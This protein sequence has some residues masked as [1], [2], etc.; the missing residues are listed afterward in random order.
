MK[1]IQLKKWGVLTAYIL[2]CGIFLERSLKPT[3]EE[4]SRLKGTLNAL[5]EERQALEIEKNDLTMQINSQSDPAWV[6][7]MLM[8]GLGLIPEGQIKVFFDQSKIAGS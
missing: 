6:E 7:L 5:Q 8:K 2:L 3:Y 4:I 1:Y